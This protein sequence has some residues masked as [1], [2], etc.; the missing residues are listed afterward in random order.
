MD[1]GRDYFI[2]VITE[3]LNER[4]PDGPKRKII[5]SRPDYILMAC[6]ICGDSEK[7]L[8]K[9]RAKFF[10]DTLQ[11]HCYHMGCH[12]NLT[13]LCSTYNVNIDP[14]KK[15]QI[16]NY[17]DSK[18]KVKKDNTDKFILQDMS[19]LIELDDVLTMFNEG[20][21]FIKNVKHIQKNG[22]VSNYLSH[23]LIPEKIYSLFYE[24]D[25]KITNKIYN[26]CVVYFNMIGTKVIGLQIRNLKSGKNRKYKIV[27]F[28]ELYELYNNEKMDNI[29]AIPYNKVSCFYNIF[30]ID[31]TK[32]IT[33][34]EGYIDSLFCYNSIGAVGTNTDLNF[35]LNDDI[36]TRFFFDNDNAGKLKAIEF[37]KKGKSVF[38]W[39]KFINEWSSKNGDYYNNKKSLSCIK[40]LNKLAEIVGTFNVFSKLKLENYFSIDMFDL[41][42]INLEKPQKYVPNKLKSLVSLKDNVVDWVFLKNQLTQT[43]T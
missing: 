43:R 26:K 32:I 40:D 6:P 41:K 42:Y 36:N 1:I 37:L 22:E 39:N 28:E 9:K 24:A 17:I 2:N 11:L 21:M 31:Y 33:I 35:F 8:Y 27:N 3:I 25:L 7:N 16:Y 30:N 19:L 5:S 29:E 14:D 18:I 10:F 15:L 20:D 34:F 13:K 12:T 23:R 4:F 38:L